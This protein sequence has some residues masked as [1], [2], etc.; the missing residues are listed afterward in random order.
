MKK[1]KFTKIFRNSEKNLLWYDTILHT[2]I[3]EKNIDILGCHNALENFHF[4]PVSVSHSLVLNVANLRILY[5]VI[6]VGDIRNCVSSPTVFC[7]RL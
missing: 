3:E 7:F 1:L 2:K 4:L 6:I 5:Y